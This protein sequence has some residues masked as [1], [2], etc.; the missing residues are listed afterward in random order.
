M[1]L[2][3]HVPHLPAVLISV[4][5]APVT[6][7]LGNDFFNYIQGMRKIEKSKIS[8]RDEADQIMQSYEKV[9]YY[10]AS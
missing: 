5:N 8:S 4:D 1:T 2:A 7:P 3:L 10:N 9:Y 6:A